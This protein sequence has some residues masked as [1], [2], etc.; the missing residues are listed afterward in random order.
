MGVILSFL[1]ALYINGVRVDA[2]AAIALVWALAEESLTK[3][4]V[5]PLSQQ[6]FARLL[7]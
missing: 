7:T 3:K 5:L 4:Q 6:E 2:T 1:K